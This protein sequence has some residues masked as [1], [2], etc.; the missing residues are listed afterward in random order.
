[1]VCAL[2]TRIIHLIKE[3]RPL[4]GHAGSPTGRLSVWAKVMV[5]TQFLLAPVT[6]LIDRYEGLW[7]FIASVT[8]FS[9]FFW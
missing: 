7:I 3:T 5:L 8:R 1:M 2:V 4:L 6:L 9:I